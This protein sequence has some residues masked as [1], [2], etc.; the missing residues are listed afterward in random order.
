M[1]VFAKE[2][3][4][5][6]SDW[7][8]LNQAY[9]AS[10]MQRLR[11]LLH[12]RVLWLRKQWK[13]D[14]LQSYQG[15]VISEAQADGLLGGEDR[16]A[17][18]RFYQ[19][20]S[21]AVRITRDL[22]AL[23]NELE[24]RASA[25]DGAGGPPA[26]EILARFF[27]LTP[28]EQDVLLLCLAPELDPAFERLY[29]YVQDDVTRKYPTP[30]LALTLFAGYP[31]NSFL[32]EAPLRRFG[33][34]SFE[35]AGASVRSAEPLRLNRRIAD[36]LLGLNR[37]DE[38]VAHALK[39]V[40]TTPLLAPAQGEVVGRL[41]RLLKSWNGC[42]RMPAIN[43][44]GPPGVGRRAVA[45]TVCNRLGIG[46][47][48]LEFT[49]LPAP[50]REQEDLYC[51]L[52]REAVLL[53][54]A[55][56][57][58]LSELDL[59]NRAEMTA[60]KEL[61]EYL[62]AVL[63]VGS[64]DP[65]PSE[66]GTT[67]IQVPKADA[68]A[69]HELWRSAVF[70]EILAS[71]GGPEVSLET[72]AQQFD[73]GPQGVHQAAELARGLARLRDPETPRLTTEDLW[74]ACRTLAAQSLEGLAQRLNPCYNWEDIVLPADVFRQLQEIAAQVAHRAK[75]YETW[76]F[77]AKLSRGRGISALFSG[78]SGT[79]KTMA[80][81][82]LAHHLQLDLYRIDL[83]GVVSKYIGETEKNLRKVFDAAEQSGAILFFDE[84]DA[85]FGKRSEV[86]DSHDRYANIEVNYLL[87]R[88][89]DYRGLAILATNMKSLLDQ[90][91][92]RRLRYLVDFPFPDASQRLRIWQKAFPACAPV[93]GVEY[94]FL[95]RLE[96]PGGN[97]KNIV[98]NAAFLAASEGLPIGM[99]HIMHAA[100]REYVKIDKL[101]L[102][103]EF[104]SYYAVVR[105]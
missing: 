25:V 70:S 21:E 85:L 50:G 104:G 14:P 23:Q 72:L 68:A 91:F 27:L 11:L 28:F 90:A 58:D 18:E 42:G 102:E 65:W 73:F 74:I 13:H 3:Q 81:E 53:P 86:K 95:A 63:F 8:M 84:A 20:D 45:R 44:V 83:S 94:D 69:Q 33:L 54:A 5:P 98:L 47:Y 75:V 12:R 57:L 66:R 38:Q 32:P 67:V 46:L 43:L 30:Y 31:W 35:P 99:A 56:Y 2:S 100:R 19:E 92:L 41:E 1:S 76:G 105:R 10:E 6:A 61:S 16:W 49:R 77:G 59:G 93:D 55:Y 87:Q 97:I 71:N 79:G 24:S 22:E 64:R 29:A 89:E 52:E 101:M 36:Y 26:L 96:I 60:A 17:E 37:M 15:L 80:A 7:A 78:P 40:E 62:R 9:L 4:V 82:I 103:S 34:I 39:P 51:I 88:M 48:K